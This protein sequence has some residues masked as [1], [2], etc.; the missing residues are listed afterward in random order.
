MIK[1]MVLNK[2]I[3]KKIIELLTFFIKMV[4]INIG[5]EIA[6]MRLPK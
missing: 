6:D 1:N 3:I 2:R 5:N 4:I